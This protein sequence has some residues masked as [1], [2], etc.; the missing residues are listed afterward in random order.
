MA[1]SSRSCPLSMPREADGFATSNGDG[2]GY[3]SDGTETVV[4]FAATTRLVMTPR[5]RSGS[6]NAQSSVT[7]NAPTPTLT[8]FFGGVVNPGSSRTAA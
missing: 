2:G 7:A 6:P 1:I 5:I 3:A 4:P 8:P